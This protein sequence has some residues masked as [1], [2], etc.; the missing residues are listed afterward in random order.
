MGGGLFPIPTTGH[1]LIARKVGRGTREEGLDQDRD[2]VKPPE[3]KLHNPL[4]GA[5]EQV[6]LPTPETQDSRALIQGP[7]SGQRSYLRQRPLRKGPDLGEE[8]SSPGTWGS[9][10]G[11]RAL[12][13]S[14]GA[15]GLPGWGSPKDQRRVHSSHHPPRSVIG[16]QWSFLEEVALCSGVLA[17]AEYWHIITTPDWA[18]GA[19]STGEHR[20]QPGTTHTDGGL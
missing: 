5:D 9:L 15:Q 11:H 20:A 18:V 14:I 10:P 3:Q 17:V 13:T 19:G 4:Q 16:F 6:P 1:W 2:R 8:S 12:L 7:R